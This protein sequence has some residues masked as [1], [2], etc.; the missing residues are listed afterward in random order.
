VVTVSVSAAT[1]R[2]LGTFFG[3]GDTGTGFLTGAAAALA[4]LG[5]GAGRRASTFRAT[6]LAAG[7]LALADFGA[8]RLAAIG[9]LLKSSL[10]CEG[11]GIIPADFRM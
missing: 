7:F 9:S 8:G 3:A 6:G 10:A 1:L 5:T 11:R 2:A 4:L